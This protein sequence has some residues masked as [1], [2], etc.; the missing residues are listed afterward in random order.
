MSLKVYLGGA[1]ADPA[2]RIDSRGFLQ[3]AEQNLEQA[4]E[5]KRNPVVITEIVTKLDSEAE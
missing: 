5:Q 4:R 1:I 2:D 3:Q